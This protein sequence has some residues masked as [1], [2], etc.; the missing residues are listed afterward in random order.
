MNK[1]KLLAW[2]A[3][4]AALMAFAVVVGSPYEPV[5]GPAADIEDI[6]AIEDMREE[7]ETPLVRELHNNG[8]PLGF[9][10]A[11]NTF[12]CPL[13]LGQGEAWPD[14]HL[15]AACSSDVHLVFVDDYAYDYCYDAVENGYSYEVMAYN[16]T[17][18]S[19]LN[20]VFTGMM[21]VHIAADEPFSEFDIPVETTFSDGSGT[22]SSHARAHYRGGVTMHADKR[23]YRV[24]FT[25]NPDGTG[26]T[27][28]ELPVF[29]Q[30]KQV[31]LIP[32]MM[33]AT[34][35][36]DRLAW[37][38][39]A[40]TRPEETCYGARKTMYV[41]V[42]V[43]GSYEGLYLMMEPFDHALELEKRAQ[44]ASAVDCT[45]R[46]GRD[47]ADKDRAVRPGG[48][49][50]EYGYEL[51]YEPVGAEQFRAL[52]AF[53]AL[54]TEESDE[55]FAARLEDVID[56]DSMIHYFLHLQAFGMIDNVF[57]NL[58]TIAHYENGAY[59]ISFAPW[60]MDMSMGTT[61]HPVDMW[62]IFPPMDRAL[63]IDAGGMRQRVLKAWQALRRDALTAENVERL[64]AGYVHEVNDSGAA[65]RDAQR[66]SKENDY[67]DGL[68]LVGFA[69]DR[70]SLLD[71]V[72]EAV[73]ATDARVPMFDNKDYPNK[74]G[75]ISEI[76]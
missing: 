67:L 28:A 22:A 48:Y 65:A 56:V 34:R 40:L 70:F 47:A 54:C 15:T 45:Y 69:A 14:I 9:D 76:P 44:G 37:D 21:Q 30:V 55:V 50:E 52:D 75:L 59:K 25:K 27:V 6:W 49:L 63:Q 4:L 58:F 13:T 57:N 29:G 72:F 62:V 36:H 71:Q 17:H 10:E 12:Y 19:Y 73:A 38:L 2:M 18:Y 32:M 35:M 5:I 7:S 53:I 33:D 31:N 74:Y 26:K 43:N 51:H 20:V 61:G 23:A 68:S 46:S 64:I 16:G 42:F 66:W 1:L 11:S 8:V 3:A 39:Y 24:E 60:D 41:E